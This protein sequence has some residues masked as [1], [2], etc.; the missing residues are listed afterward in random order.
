MTFYLFLADRHGTASGARWAL[1]GMAVKVAQSVCIKS[2]LDFGLMLTS[3]S[4]ADRSSCV[5][6]FVPC[7]SP[8]IRSIC[9]IETAVVGTA[10]THTRLN[11]DA[12]SFGRCSRTIHG[13]V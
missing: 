9:Q 1:M 8:L 10:L 13:S 12:S 5:H 7:L 6:A 11:A 3:F 2:N 4:H